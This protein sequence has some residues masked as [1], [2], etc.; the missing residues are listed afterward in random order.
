M[1]F[2]EFWQSLIIGNER[3]GN[4]QFDY[5]STQYRDLLLRPDYGTTTLATQNK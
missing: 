2:A 1:G 3:T 5:I 4:L